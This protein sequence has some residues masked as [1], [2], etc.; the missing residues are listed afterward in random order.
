MYTYT[1]MY[2][3]PLY[4]HH[5]LPIIHQIKL[6][7]YIECQYMYII[8]TSQFGFRENL[9]KNASLAILFSH[10]KTIIYLQILFAIH[11]Y[12]YTTEN[13]LTMTVHITSMV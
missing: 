6:S 4:G 1:Y 5:A 10:S 11:L 9:K 7:A 2:T 8:E 3:F 13:T 12:T